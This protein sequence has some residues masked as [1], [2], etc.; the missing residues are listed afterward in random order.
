V[1]QAEIEPRLRKLPKEILVVL[2]AVHRPSDA[3]L[4]RAERLAADYRRAERVR[5]ACMGGP[6]RLTLNKHGRVKATKKRRRT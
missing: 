3:L 5:R 4:R 6:L 2:L 1:T